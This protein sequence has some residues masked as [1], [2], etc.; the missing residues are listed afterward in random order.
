MLCKQMYAT[1]F[2]MQDEHT[3]MAQLRQ[4]TEER[5]ELFKATYKKTQ[6][7]LNEEQQQG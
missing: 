7:Q 5:L 1:I 4:H 2:C 3:N 6:E